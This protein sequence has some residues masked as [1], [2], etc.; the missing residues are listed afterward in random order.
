M[1]LDSSHVELRPTLRRFRK[2]KFGLFLR[3]HFLNLLDLNRLIEGLKLTSGIVELLL[4]N[5]AYSGDLSLKQL[6]PFFDLLL[7][8][9]ATHVVAEHPEVFTRKVE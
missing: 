7:R 4:V 8:P 5:I 2:V 6:H 9:F 3:L 1:F